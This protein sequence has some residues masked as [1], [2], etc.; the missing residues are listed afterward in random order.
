[1]SL[2]LGCHLDLRSS[3]VREHALL[4]RDV[5]RRVLNPARVEPFDAGGN[6]HTVSWGT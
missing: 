3:S 4:A 2:F 1:M 5:L 6:R